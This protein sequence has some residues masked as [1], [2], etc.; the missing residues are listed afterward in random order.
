MHIKCM[1]GVKDQL[2]LNSAQESCHLALEQAD[3]LIFQKSWGCASSVKKIVWKMNTFYFTCS[4]YSQMRY[5]L[6][7]KAINF[8]NNYLYLQTDEQFKILMDD[9][10]TKDTADF[11]NI[12]N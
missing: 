6:I 7:Q 4:F 11:C 8:H 10:L 3:I 12:F 5:K 2:W 1:T 9:D